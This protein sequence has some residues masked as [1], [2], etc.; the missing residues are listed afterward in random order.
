MILH[1]FPDK[2]RRRFWAGASLRETVFRL[3][4]CVRIR[5]NGGTA[6]ASP[7][8]NS[9]PRG[10]RLDPMAPIPPA[11]SDR[12]DPVSRPS[13]ADPRIENRPGVRSSTS[14]GI[15]I[16]AIIAVLVVI[17]YFMFGGGARIPTNEAAPPAT[18][19]QAPASTAPAEPATPP[20]TAPSSSTAPAQPA[21]QPATPAP[22]QP[23]PAAPAQ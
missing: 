18:T 22:A 6:M 14:N 13:V 20:A 17:A 8:R 21:P 3:M 1:I 9:D 2:I 11:D 5:N 12:M 10:P 23:A 19:E 16:A 7:L 4:R 15:L